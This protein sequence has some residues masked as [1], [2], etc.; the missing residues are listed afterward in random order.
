MS[1]IN[2]P[3]LK[4]LYE[5][6]QSQMTKKNIVEFKKILENNDY[7]NVFS[8]IYK[9]KILCL[10]T[11]IYLSPQSNIIEYFIKEHLGINDKLNEISGDGHKNGK[12][13]EFKVSL[14][15]KEPKFNFVQIRPSH[16]IDYY[17]LITYNHSTNQYGD[18]HVFKIPS[19]DLYELLPTYGGYAHGTIELQ[20]KITMES[21]YNNEYE[22]ALRV[23]RSVKKKDSKAHK[24]WNELLKYEVTFN[25]QDF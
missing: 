11:R 8:D 6:S 12:N 13:Y 9:L 16:N 23:D 19:K 1:Q 7:Y 20:G 24:L 4:T 21:I 5:I 25:C 14:H 22:Y 2:N 3:I 10:C 15:G 18:A 17:L